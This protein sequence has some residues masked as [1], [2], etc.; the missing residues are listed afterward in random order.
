MLFQLLFKTM[1]YL[2]IFLNIYHNFL[3]FKKEVTKRESPRLLP[4]YCTD[5]TCYTPTVLHFISSNTSP[6]DKEIELP[7]L[8]NF[9]QRNLTLFS[10]S[11]FCG[12]CITSLKTNWIT[13]YIQIKILHLNH[14]LRVKLK[15]LTFELNY[16]L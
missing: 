11:L 4:W 3:V 9:G 1:I 14:F 13:Q 6:T 16:L 12:N 10:L 15:V 2:F 5:K 8:V 7:M